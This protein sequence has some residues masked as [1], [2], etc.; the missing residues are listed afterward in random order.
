MKI[1][2]ALFLLVVLVLGTFT[3]CGYMTKGNQDLQQ[4]VNELQSLVEQRDREIQRL[5]DQLQQVIDRTSALQKELQ[6]KLSREKELQNTL[7]SLQEEFTGTRRKLKDAEDTVLQTLSQLEQVKTELEWVKGELVQ[8]NDNQSQA[9]AAFNQVVAE[10]N[11]LAEELKKS[12]ESP[13]LSGLLP[14]N[15]R[16]PAAIGYGVLLASVS[17]LGYKGYLNPHR[18]PQIPVS[19]NSVRV[20]MS[21]RT[22]REFQLFL[23]NRGK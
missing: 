9:Q 4:Q 20:T 13:L 7:A 14:E 18:R 6:N 17:L 2:T 15:L 21:E 8:T 22:Y 16:L 11:S 10:R 12:Q 5:N 23:K 19:P 3:I 1:A